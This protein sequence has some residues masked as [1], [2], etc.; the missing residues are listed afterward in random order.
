M[1]FTNPVDDRKLNLRVFDTPKN[2][3]DYAW[4][5]QNRKWPERVAR[6]D[7]CSV[8]PQERNDDKRKTQ[9]DIDAGE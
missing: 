3:Q 6:E 4:I 1:L 5:G 8:F 9:R 7:S 2:E